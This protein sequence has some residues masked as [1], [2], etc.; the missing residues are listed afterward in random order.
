M[1]RKKWTS[2]TLWSM[3]AIIFLAVAFLAVFV[4][5]AGKFEQSVYRLASENKEIPTFYSEAIRNFPIGELIIG[6]GG[7]VTVFIGGN[8]ARDIFGKPRGSDE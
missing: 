2:R 3:F 8:K 1:A 5:M 7:A 6:V 4:W